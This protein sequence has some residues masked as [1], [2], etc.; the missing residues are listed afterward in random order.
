MEQGRF[1]EA[2]RWGGGWRRIDMKQVGRAR[3]RVRTPVR[4]GVRAAPCAQAGLLLRTHSCAQGAELRVVPTSGSGPA[5]IVVWGDVR[6]GDVARLTGAMA[7]IVRGRCE[8]EAGT[9]LLL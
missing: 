8:S 7:Q 2:C 6:C 5:A 4:Y 1:E 9:P 3:A